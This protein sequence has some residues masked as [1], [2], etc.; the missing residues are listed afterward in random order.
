MD[1]T[2]NNWSLFW[3]LGPSFDRLKPY[4]YIYMDTKLRNTIMPN[5]MNNSRKLVFVF[6]REILRIYVEFL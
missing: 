1:L 3:Y 6:D 2:V 4:I 5:M